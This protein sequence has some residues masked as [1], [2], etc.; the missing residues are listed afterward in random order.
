MSAYQLDAAAVIGGVLIASIR[1]FLLGLLDAQL[2]ASES[3]Q[4]LCS[5]F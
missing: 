3:N 2:T 4:Q 1:W 5:F